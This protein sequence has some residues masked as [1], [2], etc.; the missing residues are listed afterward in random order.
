MFE[1]QDPPIIV[2][3]ILIAPRWPNAFSRNTVSL[4]E[5]CEVFITPK[6]YLSD[7]LGYELRRATAL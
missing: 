2:S 7:S 6:Q 4:E 5:V 1:S 3:T